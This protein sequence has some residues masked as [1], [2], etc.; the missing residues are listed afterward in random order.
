MRRAIAAV[1]IGVLPAA[2]PAAADPDA[3]A[4]EARGVIQGFMG[5]LKGELQG[6]M[7]EGG[8]VKAIDV[9]NQAAPGITKAHSER[10]GWEVGRT[11]LKVRNPA[12]AADAWETRVMQAFEARKAHG[13]APAGI[14]HF[15]VVERDGGKVFRYMKAIPTEEVC[16]KCH[17]EAIAAP[18]AAKLDGLYPQDRARGFREGDLR[19][20]FTLEKRL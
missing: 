10:T 15:A 6:A 18:V 1:L 19:G 7:K 16:T 11:S 3:L 4:A 13:E 20:A 2:A 5:E 17:G 12:N 14:D 9:C 8:P